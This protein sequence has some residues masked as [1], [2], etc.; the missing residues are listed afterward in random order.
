MQKN[1]VE[2]M[3]NDSDVHMNYD[4]EENWELNNM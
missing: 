3:Y 1:A 4:I 2:F